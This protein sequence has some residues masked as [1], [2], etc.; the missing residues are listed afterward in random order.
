MKSTIGKMKRSLFLLLCLALVG[1]AHAGMSFA[2]PQPGA[3]DRIKLGEILKQVDHAHVSF[4][5]PR[6][7]GDPDKASPVDPGID[8]VI[9]TDDKAWLNE[10]ST[11]LGTVDG[12][13]EWITPAMTF[14]I[15]LVALCH[16][17]KPLLELMWADDEK[18]IIY[19][20]DGSWS[21]ELKV[22]EQVLKQ[23]Q[24][25][26]AKK[27]P[28]VGIELHERSQPLK[29]LLPKIDPASFKIELPTQSAKPTPASGPRG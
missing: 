7:K 22:D 28:H 17:D 27:K 5:F 19:T 10:F 14:D 29:I 9:V 26:C 15:S 4:H 1:A 16:G 24:A 21:V 25:I 11:F 3:L 8:T 6:N 2:K 18:L 20:P 13:P 23:Y 12:T